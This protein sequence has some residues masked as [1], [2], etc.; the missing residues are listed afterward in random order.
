MPTGS[1]LRGRQKLRRPNRLA[2]PPATWSD[3]PLGRVLSFTPEHGDSLWMYTM[4]LAATPYLRMPD[5]QLRA[6]VLEELLEAR[7]S[8]T[9][10]VEP[11]AVVNWNAHRWIRGHNAYRAPGEVRRFGNLIAAPHGRIHFAG[12]HT[13]VRMMGM[14]GAM[15]SSERGSAAR[16]QAHPPHSGLG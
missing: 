10:R 16:R 15:E 12:E 6:R 3:G 14:E 5:D 9:R 1:R 4:G 11:T 7:P 2:L 13:A 8:A